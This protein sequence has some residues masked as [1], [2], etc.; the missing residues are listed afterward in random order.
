MNLNFFTVQREHTWGL[1]K[2]FCT[3]I[4]AKKV[5]GKK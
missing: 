5:L 1:R 2:F 3:K 4:E